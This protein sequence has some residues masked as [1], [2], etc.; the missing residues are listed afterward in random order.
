MAKPLLN[1]GSVMPIMG[2]LKAASVA[3]HVRVDRERELGR[4]AD[5][6]ELLAESGR[7]THL[8]SSI[9][10]NSYSTSSLLVVVLIATR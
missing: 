8:A 7:R 2:E 9:R 10:L 4:R 5:V 6:R 1:G 3:Q